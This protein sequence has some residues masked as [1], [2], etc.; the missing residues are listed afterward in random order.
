MFSNERQE[1]IVACL[2]ENGTVP[3]AELAKRLY[4]SASTV[5]RDLTELES[6]GI[7][8]RVHGGAVLTEGSAFDAPARMR[9]VRQLPEK[10]KIAEL[11]K[12]FLAGSAAY[13][14]DSSST[15]AV[16]AQALTGYPNVTVIT[17]GLGIL[18]SLQSSG[19]LTVI[20]CGGILRSPYGEFT[21]LPALQ[22]IEQMNADVFF[23][24]CGG[25][26]ETGATEF[27]DA[28]V[29]V[30]RAFYRRARTRILLCDS[31]K[32]DKRFLY[33]SFKLSEPDWIITDKK[34]SESYIKL[35]GE[36]LIWDNCQI[37]PAG[38]DIAPKY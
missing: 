30:K 18:N 16:L 36:R 14:F 23:F 12:G 24:S 9:R 19:E 29:A 15:S 22:T 34:P 20:G 11:A 37:S 6:F 5:R 17:N 1:Q 4:A 13:F 10:Q 33:R 8:H 32:L 28:N 25:L 27:S 3:V 26:D 31:T 7:L 21:G 35:L 2:R 38:I